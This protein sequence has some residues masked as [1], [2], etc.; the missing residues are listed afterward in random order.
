MH[1]Q[2]GTVVQWS[3]PSAWPCLEDT[4][5]SAVPSPQCNQHPLC[6]LPYLQHPPPSPRSF[7]TGL[8]AACK[9]NQ[10]SHLERILKDLAAGRGLGFLH[11]EGLSSPPAF[12]SPSL[13]SPSSLQ[14]PTPHPQQENF[15]LLLPLCNQHPNLCP[16]CILPCNF[17][18][19]GTAN[20]PEGLLATGRNPWGARGGR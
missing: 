10:S 17:L 9:G 11:V 1:H 5:V 15:L 3:W 18:L 12:G 13:S 16:A 20:R 4:Q 19:R 14:L 8:A 6:T 2:V 7:P